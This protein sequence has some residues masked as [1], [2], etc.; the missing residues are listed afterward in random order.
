MD[1]TLLAKFVTGKDRKKVFRY[2]TAPPISE[3][4]LKAVADVVTVGPLAFKKD[5]DAAKRV[6]D[7]VLSI[8][9]PHR[10]RWIAEKRKP[11]ATE[12]DSAIM[13]SAA[14][15]AARE[16][17]S[18][19]RN[20][21]KDVQEKSV[22]NVLKQHGLTEV[23]PRDIPMLTAAPL[24]G[25]F[26]G[27]SRIA[28]TRADVVVRM[29]DQR[30]MAIECKVSNSAVNSYKR[31]IHDTGGKAAHWYNQLGK[32]QVVP[33]AVLSGVFKASN[34][35]SVQE[36]GVYLFWQHRLADITDFIG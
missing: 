20:T 11:T 23:P 34:F 4:D 21:S 1:A 10:F 30:V 15:A 7:T 19:R 33:C 13:A 8:L 17:E 2:I 12:L 18:K 9:D 36:S 32:A 3:D 28:G 29:K 22:K 35:L 14:M 26:C 25:E 16:V 27:E 5:H 31:V 6:R 24:P